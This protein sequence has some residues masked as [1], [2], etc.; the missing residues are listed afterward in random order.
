MFCVLFSL[1][2]IMHLILSF[3]FYLSLEEKFYSFFSFII[4]NILSA[5][6]SAQTFAIN[7][8]GYRI[9]LMST[10]YLKYKFRE[11]NQKIELNL[12]NRNI[13]LLMYAIKEHNYME[14]MTKKLNYTFRMVIFIIYYVST[15]SFQLLVY[16]THHKDSKPLARIIAGFLFITSFWGIVVMNAMSTGVI[17]SAHMSYPV[18]YKTISKGIRMHFRHRW[19]LL[20]FIEKLSGPPIGFYCYD[21]FP[22]NSYEFYQYL[23]IAGSNYLLIMSMF[24]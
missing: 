24:G 1:T 5:I 12:K 9:W 11:I 6:F 17:R 21:L 23:C 22:M 18:L 15:I 4:F 2:S 14:V 3:M 13:I 10:N 16:N 20:S 19:K 7:Y 8:I